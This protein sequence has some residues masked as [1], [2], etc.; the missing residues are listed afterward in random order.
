LANSGAILQ[1]SDSD[2][3]DVKIVEYATSHDTFWAAGMRIAWEKA[4]DYLPV[5]NWVLW[6]NDDTE[7][8]SDSILT[9]VNSMETRGSKRL[10]AVG[11]CRDSGGEISYGG[12]LSVGSVTPL[13]M[14]QL[15]ISDQVQECDTFN[16]NVVFMDYQSFKNLGGFPTGYTH[17]R[18][19][20]DFGFTAKKKSLRAIV[21]PG[22]IAT[23]EKN[24]A[25]EDFKD[26]KGMSLLARFK[27]IN[28]PKFGPFTEHFRLC[29]R[30]GGWFG[31]I[32]G[33]A[34]L[35]RVIKAK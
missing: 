16:G 3:A 26:L 14:V 12:F 4:R 19:D 5:C 11:A 17:L 8:D 9:L 6:L 1:G 21:V 18:A 24:L 23:C 10:I 2:V 32:Y 34:P 35:Y 33:L 29:L 20:I 15:G 27:K 28:G 22:T 25:Y 30:H 31:L 13:N 7:L